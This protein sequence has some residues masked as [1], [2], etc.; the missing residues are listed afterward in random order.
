MGSQ[1]TDITLERHEPVLPR[2]A[3]ITFI[4]PMGASIFLLGLADL[5]GSTSSYS[6]L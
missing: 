3:K 5:G 4:V 1:A 2:A 6:L